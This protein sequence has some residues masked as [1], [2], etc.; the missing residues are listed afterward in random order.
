MPHII[1]GWPFITWKL[2]FDS[3]YSWIWISPQVGYYQLIG[4]PTDGGITKQYHAIIEILNI[5]KT[6]SKKIIL[7]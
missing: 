7:K 1:Y 5:I 4:L 2:L 6:E 3:C